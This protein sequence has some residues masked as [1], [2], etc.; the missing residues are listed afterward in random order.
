VAAIAIAPSVGLSVYRLGWFWLCIESAAL[1][2]TMA[3]IAFNLHRDPP[4][5]RGRIE[6]QHGPVLEWRVLVLSFSLFLYTFGYGG[7]TSF[8]AMYADAVGVR[9]A[10]IYL[11][12]L[13]IV[14][15]LT[16][17]ISGRLGDRWGYTKVFVPCLVL[18]SAGFACLWAGS[19]LGWMLTSAI[20]FGTGYGTAYPAFV[21]YVMQGVAAER[22]GAAF[23]AIL[24]AFDTG[25][26]SGSTSL[27]WLIE[28]YGYQPAF[29][30]AALLSALALPYFLITDR[31]L[32]YRRRP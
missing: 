3:V 32:G 17:P 29:G 21:G 15:L 11:T 19:S 23:G 30:A 4:I 10:S 24:A 22:R 12:T 18:I 5:R 16:R 7:I 1:N 9:P 8:A 2:I 26:G 31:I 13:A 27:G 28:R 14:I 6:R 25:I 20:I